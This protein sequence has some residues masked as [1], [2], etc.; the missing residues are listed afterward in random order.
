MLSDASFWEALSCFKGPV[1]ASHQNCRTLV[2]GPRQFTDDQ[3]KA[4]LE[5]DAV[6]GHAL[7]NWQLYPDYVRGQTPKSAISLTH[8]IDQIEHVSQLAGNARHSAIGSD[9]DGIFGFEQT[10]GEVDTI[11]DVQ[12]LPALLSARGYSD[13]ECAGIMTGNAIEFFRRYCHVKGDRLGDC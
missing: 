13:A 6:I 2:P 8:F 1:F 12:K 3:L 11:A 4:L 9:L 7:D 10:P 5:R